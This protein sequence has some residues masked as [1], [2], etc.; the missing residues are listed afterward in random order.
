[1]VIRATSQEISTRNNGFAS[2]LNCLA[3]GEF[4]TSTHYLQKGNDTSHLTGLKRDKVHK[5]SSKVPTV[6]EASRKARCNS[7]EELALPDLRVRGLLPLT[8][9]RRETRQEPPT[10]DTPKAYPCASHLLPLFS[11]FFLIFKNT[12]SFKAF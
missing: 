11:D 5:A 10:V 6:Q 2:L 7:A 9:V 1:M 4:L 3:L 8:P 12:L